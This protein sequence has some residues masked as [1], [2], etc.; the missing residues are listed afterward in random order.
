MGILAGQPITAL[1]T[2]DRSLR[3]RPMRRVTEPLEAMGARFDPAG[4]DRLPITVRGGRLR[5]IRWELPVSSAQLKSA[6]LLAG[7]VGRVP[8]AVREPG[9]LSRD[10]TERMLRGLGQ[11]VET[12]DGW[13]EF[14][15][16][17]PLVPF[18]LTVP[19]DPSSAAFLVG[20][21]TLGVVTRELV[22]DHIGQNPTR[23]A[24][25]DV[26]A[27]MGGQ[28]ERRVDED[29]LGEPVGTL[30]VYPAEL[31]ATTVEAKE[32]PGLID[33][34]PLLAVLAARAVGTSRFEN[35]GELRIKESD[36]LSLIA[37]NLTALGYDAGV[38]G[39][40]LV[41]RGSDHPPRG[42]VRTQGDHR[43]AMAF[44]VLARVPGARVTIDDRACAD[45][46]YPGFF[47]QLARIGRRR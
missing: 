25:L 26:I 13:I 36:R 19:R 39:E 35:V 3:G 15:P 20:A 34:I 24:Y 21:A 23:T 38:E 33:E 42:R 9:G 10:H 6:I 5:G 37:A 7:L 44:G 11:A 22:L 46:S 47:E 41:I 14:V 27:R 4:A 18:D 8:V 1:V 45:V 30:V 12:T 29:L 17:A 43:I 2:G 40:T 28:I 32:I 31:G 16:G